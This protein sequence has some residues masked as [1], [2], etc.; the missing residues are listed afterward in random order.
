MPDSSATS[1][2]SATFLARYPETEAIDV[3][4]ADLSGVIRGKR[5]PVEDLEKVMQDGV[6]FPAS[7]FMLDTM[8][9][10]HDPGGKG[11]SDGDPDCTAHPLPGSLVPV[12]WSDTPLAQLLLT[13]HNAEEQPLYFEP[14]NILAGV[15]KRVREL[16]L[17]P[18]VA[19]EL[20][21]Y[22]LDRERLDGNAP[23]P[24]ISPLTGLRE[25]GTQVYGMEQVD[26]F[27]GLLRDI[28]RAC[29]AQSIPTGAIS[30]EYAPGQFE[31][32]LRHVDDALKAADD[33]VLFKRA[34]KGVARRHGHKA[35]FM[36]KP[37]P[38]EAGS[39][40]HM[41]VSLLDKKG[42]NVLDGGDE[43]AS[44]TLR[45]AI[46]GLLDLLPQSMAFLA[47]NVNSF[48]RF[49]PNI[50]VPVTRSWGFENRSVAMRV[51]LGPA[52][53][54]RIEHRVAGADANPYL[55]LASMLAGIHH[56]IV[57]EI[58][59]GTPHE[60][61]ASEK[62]DTVLPMR[63]RRAIDKMRR[64]KILPDYLGADYPSL[65]AEC[66]EAEYDEFDWLISPQEYEWYL[67]TD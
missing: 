20:E 16:E 56:G 32:N 26:G 66:K 39:G 25:S 52:H 42:R 48:R 49:A 8:G 5:Y 3:L 31:I 36:A 6:A 40:M 22:L 50:F 17:T 63:P 41:H 29:E 55:A 61:N 7:V 10:S 37:Y 57:N 58:D 47:P 21:F 45:H 23:Q 38:G 14:R 4:L 24:P 9:H 46:G 19:F 51:P 30:A 64:S 27:S 59:P 12:P 33:C 60:G 54:R 65:Y 28:S 53:A 34:V 43:L 67:Q 18:V 13:F 35:T 62:F 1:S 2:E 44:P 15:L 11:F